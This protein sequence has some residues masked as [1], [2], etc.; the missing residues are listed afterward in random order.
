MAAARATR[1]R[2][3]RWADVG[4]KRPHASM[5]QPVFSSSGALKRKPL[6]RFP[7]WGGAAH[8]CKRTAAPA[9]SMLRCRG[10]QG[11]WGQRGLRWCHVHRA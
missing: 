6:R 1:T 9:Y 5:D 11:E 8:P 4:N 3:D 7:V 2:S 10:R